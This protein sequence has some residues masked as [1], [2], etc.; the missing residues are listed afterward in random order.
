MRTVLLTSFVCLSSASLPAQ[1]DAWLVAR[2]PALQAL[3]RHLHENPEL[4]FREHATAALMAKELR[5]L[6][7]EVTEQVTT[8]CGPRS[9][10]EIVPTLPTVVPLNPMPSTVQLN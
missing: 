5:D 2:A 10:R 9:V 1:D 3:Y 4:S 6:G 7:L 8:D